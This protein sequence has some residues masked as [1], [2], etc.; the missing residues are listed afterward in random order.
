MSTTCTQVEKKIL[1]MSSSP[2]GILSLGIIFH[3]SQTC[4]SIPSLSLLYTS[5]S[6]PSYPN[7]P[8]PLPTKMSTHHHRNRKHTHIHSRT[9]S[10]THSKKL[11][12]TTPLP[13]N[14]A[15]LSKRDFER[16]EP[17]FALYLDVQ[18]GLALERLAER[19]VRG[20]WRGF[21]GRW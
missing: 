3:L 13:L 21:V 8:H 11:P 17:L 12:T 7:K 10:R 5:S 15:P 18:K 14:A 2:N 6:I 4:L 1:L 20:R 16:F 9:H 19:E